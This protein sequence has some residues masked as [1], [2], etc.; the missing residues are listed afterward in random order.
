M[1]VKSLFVMHCPELAAF[2]IGVNLKS[3]RVNVNNSRVWIDGRE[4]TVFRE[5]HVI[6]KESIALIKV[7]AMLLSTILYV[8][9][10]VTLSHIG[11]MKTPPG[12]GRCA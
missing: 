2:G 6:A 3:Q 4:S 10:L 11:L 8:A 1:Y 9:P 5:L 7:R 12:C